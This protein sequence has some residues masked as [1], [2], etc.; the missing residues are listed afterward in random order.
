MISTKH[1]NIILEASREK[2]LNRDYITQSAKNIIKSFVP[3]FDVSD[4]LFQTEKSDKMIRIINNIDYTKLNEIYHRKSSPSHSSITQA[5]I[6]SHLSGVESD[7]YYA[8]CYGAE[9]ANSKLS[10]DLIQLPSSL[11]RFHPTNLSS[12][13]LTAVG[14]YNFRHSHYGAVTKSPII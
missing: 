7:L 2:V 12:E 4:I 9:L 5:T 10:S 1:D 14:L 3:E 11:N 6:F 13:T 8:S